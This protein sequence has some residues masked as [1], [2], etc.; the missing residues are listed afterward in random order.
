[1]KTKAAILLKLGTPLII[2]ELEIPKLEVGQVL[3]KIAYSSICG[4]QLGEISGAKGEDKYLPH[5]LGHE[6]GGVVVLTG[7]GISTV[8][9]GD[10]VAIHWRKGSGI[11]AKPPRYKRSNGGYVGAGKVATFS[12]LSVISENRL[13][14]VQEDFGLDIVALMGC[15]VTTGLGIINNEAKLKMGQS[16]AVLGCG[17]VGLN[18]IQG[19][20]MVSGNPIV[21]IDIYGGKLMLAAELGATHIINLKEEGESFS[22]FKKV[23]GE[24]SDIDI[25]VVC[26][27]TATSIEWAYSLTAPGGKCII[28]GQPN[29]TDVL[30]VN[31]FAEH[32][33]GKTL[34]DS[35]GGLTDPTVD[36]PRYLELYRQKKLNLDRLITHVF[37]LEEINKAMKVA[38]SW[39][40]AKVMLEMK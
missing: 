4:R 10:H 27:G 19:A 26:G 18:V 6:G 31:N 24:I 3:V 29:I 7:E 15:S 11:D 30:T 28:T 32:L 9:E 35:Q 33:T 17:G 37:K 36:I 21:G 38:F 40:C 34:M 8:K 23:L 1:M 13:T 22:E 2:E 20:S 39:E 5:L 16:I 14:K 25:F 12:E